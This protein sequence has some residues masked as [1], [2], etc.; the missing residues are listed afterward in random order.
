MARFVTLWG[1][2]DTKIKTFKDVIFDCCHSHT[3]IHA[4]SESFRFIDEFDFIVMRDLKTVVY[5]K[6][7]IYFVIVR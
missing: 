4:K 1:W 7:G 6:S 3:V 5:L 2:D